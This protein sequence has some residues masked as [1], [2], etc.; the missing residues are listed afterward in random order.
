[1]LESHLFTGALQRC[2][3]VQHACLVL[4]PLPKTY[5]NKAVT[6]KIFM[7]LYF[8]TQ[9]WGISVLQQVNHC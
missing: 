3:F 8:A 7:Q 1:M 5:I 6:S 9:M 2:L 4:E